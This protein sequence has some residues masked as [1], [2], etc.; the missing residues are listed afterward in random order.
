MKP[1]TLDD[2]TGES[3]VAGDQIQ[4]RRCPVCG[5]ERW[6]TYVHPESGMWICFT[7]ACGA[8]GKVEVTRDV[9]TLAS[10]L[11]PQASPYWAWDRWAEV[12][13]PNNQHCLLTNS[14][15][16]LAQRGVSVK[17]RNSLK[18]VSGRFHDSDWYNKII[19]PF[20]DPKGRII[21]WSARQFE[22]D[23]GPRKYLNCPNVKHPL[24]VPNY[25]T[26]SGRVYEYANPLVVV[27]GPFDAIA[28]YQAGYFTAALGGTTL[29]RHLKKI[30]LDMARSQVVIF[31]DHDALTKA[32]K[33]A[34]NLEAHADVRIVRPPR[35]KDPG[36]LNP[37]EIKELLR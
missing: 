19:I 9:E 28:C 31:L 8:S 21:Y 1:Q 33:L 30:L 23:P 22:G 25:A 17:V 3:R 20:Y 35:G 32:V 4:F 11:R 18:L 29:P 16:W 10:V 13:L 12:D 24:Y 26:H 27:E 6:K 7:G 5:D 14:E 36:D 2:F 37:N 15:Q 34:K